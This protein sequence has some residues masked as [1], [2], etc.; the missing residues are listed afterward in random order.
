[1]NRRQLL[2][3]FLVAPVAAAVGW[4]P[5]GFRPYTGCKFGAGLE[6]FAPW[7]PDV[8]RPE[9]PT[10]WTVDTLLRTAP[11]TKLDPYYEHVTDLA[12]E[13]LGNQLGMETPAELRADV[14]TMRIDGAVVYDAQTGR[15]CT[16][17]FPKW[18]NLGLEQWWQ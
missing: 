10:Y 18:Q 8:P 12:L 4:K 16:I 17:D 6:Q 15:S 11:R 13:R 5:S 7:P 14:T 1:M 2:G 9:V 3:M